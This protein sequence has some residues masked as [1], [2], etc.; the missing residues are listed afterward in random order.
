[1][2]LVGYGEDA[3]GEYFR[4]YDPGRGVEFE[5]EAISENNKLYLQSDFISGYYKNKTYTITQI[6]KYF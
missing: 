5:F 6:N 4:F 3:K 1:M 2:V